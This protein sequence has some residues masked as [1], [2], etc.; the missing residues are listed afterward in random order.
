M[1]ANSEAALSLNE[2]T[3]PNCPLSQGIHIEVHG[4]GQFVI[5]APQRAAPAT[6]VDLHQPAAMGVHPQR[7]IGGRGADAEMFG[8]SPVRRR[9][10]PF[11]STG[12]VPCRSHSRRHRHP[13]LLT[14]SLAM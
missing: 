14:G 12:M 8:G 6:M 11:F 4:S 2:D 13:S 5:A 9:P 3:E 7:R 1:E 10:L